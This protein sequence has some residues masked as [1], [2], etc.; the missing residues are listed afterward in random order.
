[1]FQFASFAS[2]P[3]F[4]RCRYH[5]SSMVG[6]PIRIPPAQRSLTTHRGFSQSTTSFIASKRQ[7][8]HH[9]PLISYI[10]IFLFYFFSFSSLFVKDHLQDF[11][12]PFSIYMR[13]S[14]LELLIVL[15]IDKK[16]EATRFELATPCV[17]GRCSPAEL[18][19]R[20]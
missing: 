12:L 3:Y 18:R 17:Q 5:A 11:Y 2:T 13:R 7:N 14:S 8:I 16:M 4:F 6:C 15:S 19:P 1:M 20:F 10:S 9:I